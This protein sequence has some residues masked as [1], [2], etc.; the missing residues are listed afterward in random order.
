MNKPSDY[1]ENVF[2]LV[3]ICTNG[4]RQALI[5]REP[6]GAWIDGMYTVLAGNRIERHPDEDAPSLSNPI[7]VTEFYGAAL[8]RAR[9]WCGWDWHPH[10]DKPEDMP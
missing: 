7:T 10:P 9:S 8:R 6:V 3:T 1:I 5:V 4:N 2:D